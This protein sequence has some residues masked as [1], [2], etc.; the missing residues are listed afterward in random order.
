MPLPNS[1]NKAPPQLTGIQITI[2]LYLGTSEGSVTLKSANPKDNPIVNLNLLATE[3]DV[4]KMADGVQLAS[5]IMDSSYLQDIVDSRT[6]PTNNILRNKNKFH[7]WL[8]STTTT[9]NHLTSTC[10]M[11]KSSNKF[12]VVDENCRVFGVDNLYIA[13]ASIMPDTVRA[14][15]NVTTMMIGEKV[16]DFLKGRD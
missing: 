16:S 6:S 1:H 15:T 5:E 13:D 2:S 11:G 12:A 10:S 7:E 8:R 4:H 9:G 3:S 14:N